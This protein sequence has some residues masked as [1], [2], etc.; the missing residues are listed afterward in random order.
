MSGLVGCWEGIGTV[1]GTVGGSG[2]W[3]RPSGTTGI[4]IGGWGRGRC[5]IGGSGTVSGGGTTSGGR[6]IRRG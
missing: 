6:P 1:V 3:C 4:D 2:R 5:G